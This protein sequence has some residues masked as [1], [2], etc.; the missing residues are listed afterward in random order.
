MKVSDLGVEFIKREEG[1]RLRAYED[2]AGKLTIGH[3]HL[4]Q[5]DDDLALTITQEEA[6]QLLRDDLVEA[7][8]SV[9]S[10]VKVPLGQHQFDSCCS[11]VFNLGHGN[12]RR[13][14]LLKKLNARDYAAVPAQ[15]KRWVYA[16]D[17]DGDGDVDY[18]DRVRGLVRR[19]EREARLFAEGDYGLG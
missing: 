19:R 8:D 14:T 11:F 4:I 6:E 15:M 13:S 1:L 12:L 3:G 10:L 17:Q 2:V 7:E 18:D 16:G 9:N 5:P